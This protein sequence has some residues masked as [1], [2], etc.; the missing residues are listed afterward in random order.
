[1]IRSI[2][3][4]TKK[5]K[6]KVKKKKEKKKEKNVSKIS[7]INMACKRFE[8]LSLL[9]MNNDGTY[10]HIHACAQSKLFNYF[11]TV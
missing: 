5:K 2:H 8:I 3:V 6:K 9:L 1:M 10:M 4:F 7:Q 11:E